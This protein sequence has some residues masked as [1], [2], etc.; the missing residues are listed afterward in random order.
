MDKTAT[1]YSEINSQEVADLRDIM[2]K[3][4]DSNAS[5]VVAD[6]KSKKCI[7]DSKLVIGEFANALSREIIPS[8]EQYKV[9]SIAFVHVLSQ[10]LSEH[11]DTL[12]HYVKDKRAYFVIIIMRYYVSQE[13]R[14]TNFEIKYKKSIISKNG[15]EYYQINTD[16]VFSMLTIDDIYH[17]PL[18]PLLDDFIIKSSLESD[19]HP[20]KCIIEMLRDHECNTCKLYA[21]HDNYSKKFGIVLIGNSTL[22]FLKNTTVIFTRGYMVIQYKNFYVHL[23][24]SLQGL[25]VVKTYSPESGSKM[26][27]VCSV[28]NF[29]EELLHVCNRFKTNEEEYIPRTQMDDLAIS[30][31]KKITDKLIEN[32]RTTNGLDDKP[33]NIRILFLYLK[34]QKIIEWFECHNI[35]WLLGYRNNNY[36]ALMANMHINVEKI[37]KELAEVRNTREQIAKKENIKQRFKTKLSQAHQSRHNK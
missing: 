10:I 16:H 30:I 23:D 33:I 27:S 37:L 32:I 6:I 15:D 17:I 8:I 20:M 4:V 5:D 1:Y 12:P 22:V 24:Y 9:I 19:I 7:S 13:F 18:L 21:N 14:M 11:E 35:L 36:P 2:D 3:I 26:I 34:H 31:D 25:Y 28:Y 29:D